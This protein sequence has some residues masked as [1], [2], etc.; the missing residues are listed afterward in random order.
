MT[1]SLDDTRP[2][3]G[4]S[5]LDEHLG[6]EPNHIVTAAREQVARSHG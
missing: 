4:P 2:I 6:F 5:A 3:V 1:A